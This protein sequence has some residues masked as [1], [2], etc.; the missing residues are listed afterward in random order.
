MFAYTHPDHGR[1]CHRHRPRH[2][3][4]A[5]HEGEQLGVTGAPPT[6]DIRISTYPKQCTQS[7]ILEEAMTIR[8]ISAD[9][10]TNDNTS[11]SVEQLTPREWQ[12]L[13]FVVQ[14]LT[15]KEIAERLVIS[16]HTVRHHVGHILGKV[17]CARR[18]D[19]ARLFATYTEP[20]SARTEEDYTP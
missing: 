20:D 4:S 13:A 7:S 18:V 9:T 11:Y 10:P 15:N 17:G 6:N 19:L 14:G 3:H 1:K 12:V 5:D 8:E 16:S 2:R